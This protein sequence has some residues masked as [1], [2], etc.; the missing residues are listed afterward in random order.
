LS[1]LA[2]HGEEIAQRDQI[3]G[4]RKVHIYLGATKL[5]GETW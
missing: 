2:E 4:E 1:I 3:L 5:P